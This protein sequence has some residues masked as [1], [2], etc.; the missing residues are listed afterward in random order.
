MKGAQ[1]AIVLGSF[2]SD[3][4][5]VMLA[6][7]K[8]EFEAKGLAM[9]SVV[10]V[11]GAYE[12]PLA[13]KRLLLRKEVAGVVVLGII[14]RGETAHGRV[15]G[16]SVSDALIRLQ[17]EFMRP[18]GIGI[19]GPGAEPSHVERRLESYA[20]AAVAAVSAMLQD[21]STRMNA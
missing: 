18:I 5:E 6:A 7:A 3:E 1:V 13:A 4:M 20:R 15:M 11:P 8:D 14:E 2:H 9:H 10:R 21:A 12:K 19:I 17:L 16:Q